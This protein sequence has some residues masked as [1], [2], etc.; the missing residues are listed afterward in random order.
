MELMI[1]TLLKHVTANQGEIRTWADGITRKKTGKKWVVVS[2]ERTMEQKKIDVQR[3]GRIY[4]DYAMATNLGGVVEQSLQSMGVHG[5][6]S[7]VDKIKTGSQDT[8]H[9]IYKQIVDTIK[10]DTAPQGDKQAAID[11]IGRSLVALKQQFVTGPKTQLTVS[12]TSKKGKGTTY[13]KYEKE[14]KL[15]TI[16]ASAL[17][18]AKKKMGG[19]NVTGKLE[20]KHIKEMIANKSA[21]LTYGKID[22][23]KK[24]EMPY[25]LEDIE[26]KYKGKSLLI[27]VKQTRKMKERTRAIAKV[28]IKIPY[29]YA[30]AF[31]QSQVKT[32]KTANKII[33]K[34]ERSS[35]YRDFLE[36]SGA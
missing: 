15:P 33:F 12:V 25:K 27:K 3:K 26:L 31:L 34:M 36:R 21:K 13:R 2:T 28:E 19:W 29:A 7:L 22:S 4:F 18:T 23:K 30:K 11:M 32:K 16:K 20:S 14:D 17:R 10:A 8:A 1:R 24:W 6:D 35:G 9:K 5:Y